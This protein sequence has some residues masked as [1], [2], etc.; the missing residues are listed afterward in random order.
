MQ[1]KQKVSKLLYLVGILLIVAALI[2]GLIAGVSAISTGSVVNQYKTVQGTIEK[3]TLKDGAAGI[4][5]GDVF[6]KYE[7]DGVKYDDIQI[8]TY[9]DPP[10]TG[11]TVLVYYDPADPSKTIP[12]SPTSAPA[13]NPG[14]LAV[15]FLIIGAVMI[16]SG[17][18]Y[19]H[20][21]TD[22][23]VRTH[24][25]SYESYGGDCT[26]RAG[27]LFNR[28][29]DPS[30]TKL[31]GDSYVDSPKNRRIRQQKKLFGLDEYDTY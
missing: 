10:T 19:G 27:E 23:E 14:S 7:V 11:T 25:K 21:R 20:F 3:V 1:N 15:I 2:C 26:E 24:F 6:V 12:F 28:E 8:Y 16:V 29:V 13:G 17:Y 31:Y 30:E 22:E 4:E 5:Y 18:A 9:P